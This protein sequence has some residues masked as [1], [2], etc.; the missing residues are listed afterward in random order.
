MLLSG[1]CPSG[2]KAHGQHAGCVN[3][4]SEAIS[5]MV[6]IL[7]SLKGQAAS[8][9]IEPMRSALTSHDPACN[10]GEG[11]VFKCTL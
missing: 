4:L 8:L 6:Y 10:H 2:P 3:A 11:R 7:D 5:Q 9:K 1:T